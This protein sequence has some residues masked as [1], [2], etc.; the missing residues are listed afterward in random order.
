MVTSED[1]SLLFMVASHQLGVVCQREWVSATR[2][3]REQRDHR[4]PASRPQCQAPSPRI[5][6]RYESE[7]LRNLPLPPRQPSVGTNRGNSD[8]IGRW[9]ARTSA[10]LRVKYPALSGVAQTRGPRAQSVQLCALTWASRF[11]PDASWVGQA[12]TGLPA[13]LST[14]R[15]PMGSE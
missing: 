13:Q 7:A 11:A 6:W 15:Q 2:T 5:H 4:E 1:P 9:R 10:L 14:A 8:H 12:T 3:S